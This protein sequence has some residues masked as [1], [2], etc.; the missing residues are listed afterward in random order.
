MAEVYIRRI[1]IKGLWNICDLAWELTPDVNILA[2]SNGSGKSTVLRCLSDLFTLGTISTGHRCRMQAIE[3]EFTDGTSVSSEQPFDPSIYNVSVIST[4]DT[5]LQ[6]SE[7]IYKLSDG[8]VATYLDWELYKLQNRYLTYQ[9]EIGKHVIGALQMGKS[10]ADIQAFTARKT[11]YLDTIDALLEATGKR[12]D[13][14]SDTLQFKTKYG[15]TIRPD[16][17]SSGEKQIL[18]ILTH[19]L[20]QSGRNF[21]LIMDEP[22]ISLHFD[23]QRRLIEDIRRLNPNLQLIVATHSPAVVMNGWT[24][25]VSEIG[26]LV[27][28]ISKE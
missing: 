12:V 10:T 2:G 19:V 13:R 23:W 25:R 24:D 27:R 7:A 5:T 4:F 20:I 6:E 11:L 14:D 26:D 16:Q 1:E 21:I 22:E 9:L 18:I 28:P 17:L 15:A 8:T 3:V